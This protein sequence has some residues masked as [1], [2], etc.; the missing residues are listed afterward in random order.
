MTFLSITGGTTVISVWRCFFFFCYY[1]CDC[2]CLFI[3]N[4]FNGISI[5]LHRV[6]RQSAPRAFEKPFRRCSYFVVRLHRNCNDTHFNFSR[7]VTHKLCD[8]NSR[9]EKIP[10]WLGSFERVPVRG[11]VLIPMLIYICVFHAFDMLN[12]FDAINHF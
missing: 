7:I 8:N 5:C 1:N 2:Y 12:A 6:C 11:S 4:K 10:E 3:D 9:T